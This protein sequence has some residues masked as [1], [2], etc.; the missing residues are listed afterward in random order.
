MGLLLPG[1]SEVELVKRLTA[2]ALQHCE[3]K[4]KTAQPQYD[5]YQKS[6]GVPLISPRS[7]P[8][9]CELTFA[10]A[11]DRNQRQKTSRSGQFGPGVW[12]VVFDFWGGGP[13][14]SLIFR[15]LLL[16]EAEAHDDDAV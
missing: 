7:D 11:C 4:A 3:I 14:S 8:R 6:R 13:K 15:V 16:G 10:V 9:A 5:L 1:E 2:G 12:F